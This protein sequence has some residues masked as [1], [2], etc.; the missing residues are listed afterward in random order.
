MGWHQ[1]HDFAMQVKAMVKSAHL[2]KTNSLALLGFLVQL[3][4]NLNQ[5]VCVI[6]PILDNE[7]GQK[8]HKKSVSNNIS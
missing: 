3:V 1:D 7:F 4:Q 8:T 6:H 2:D 5:N